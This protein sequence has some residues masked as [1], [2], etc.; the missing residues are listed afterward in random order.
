MYSISTHQQSIA[1]PPKL[2]TA[3]PQSWRLAI[4][5]ISDSSA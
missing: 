4:R 5:G 2:T 1:V 3:S